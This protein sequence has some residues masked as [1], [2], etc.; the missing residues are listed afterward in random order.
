MPSA[1]QTRPKPPAIRPFQ[2][3]IEPPQT[4]LHL[5][6]QEHQPRSLRLV[7][8]LRQLSTPVALILVLGVLPIYGWSVLTQ[9][10]WGKGY[11]R[12]EE[13]RRD[14]NM[15]VQKTETQ[16][17][18]VTERAEQNPKGLVP[19]GPNNT[20]LVPL[21][22]PRPTVFQTPQRTPF[23]PDGNPPLAY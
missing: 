13:L 19:Q 11:Q 2:P 15:M 12:L 1:V 10:S 18:D 9:R 8:K 16:K 23:N 22:Q 5:L 3:K 20:L 14:E 17:H 6:H 21:S 4:Q 7:N